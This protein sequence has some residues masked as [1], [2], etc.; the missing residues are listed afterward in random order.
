[1][2]TR[3]V[4]D[5][6]KNFGRE[7]APE[8][9]QAIRLRIPGY[10]ALHST[11]RALL[12]CQLPPQ[13]RILVVA[14]GTGQEL[15]SCAEGRPGWSFVGVDPSADMLDIARTKI[16]SVGLGDRVQL[17]CG[18]T[19]ELPASER[20]DAATAL[21]VMHF[22]P[23]DGS[24]HSFLQAIAER[25]KPGAPLLLAD[26][27]GEPGT[28]EF[29]TLFAAWQSH[30]AAALGVPADDPAV[31]KEF[32]ERR[33]RAGWGDEARHAELFAATGFATPI[34]FW[35]GLLFRAWVMRKA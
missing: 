26:L 19:V 21:L 1:M 28:D 7:G 6:N 4:F 18:S 27:T 5:L 25:M 16:A 24:K 35:A 13:A 30:Y 15:V 10:E 14:A 8:Y 11:A 3:T 33:S 2:D 31:A 20:F 32:A 9:D 22:L 17:F 34:R 12:E 29:E 23:D